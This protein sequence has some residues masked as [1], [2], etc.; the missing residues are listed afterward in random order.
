[1]RLIM[2]KI[3]VQ[4]AYTLLLMGFLMMSAPSWCSED[5]RMSQLAFPL[6]IRLEGVGFFYGVGGQLG[7]VIDR[8][9]DIMALKS[10]GSVDAEGFLFRRIPLYKDIFT[11]DYGFANVNEV[12]FES[13]YIRGF[14]KDHPFKQVMK[15]KG[16]FISLSTKRF[17]DV[18]KVGGGFGDTFVRFRGYKRMDGT[19]I[20]FF[21]A[22]LHDFNTQLHFLNFDL[23]ALNNQGHHLGFKGGLTRVT[24]RLGQSDQLVANFNVLYRWELHSQMKLIFSTKSSHAKVTKRYSSLST[25]KGQCETI[26][27]QDL[28]RECKR[29]EDKVNHFINR[30]NFQG[31][32][33]PLGGSLGMRAYRELRFKSAHTAMSMVAFDWNPVKNFPLE[34]S[35]FFELGH[36]S[37][38]YGKLYKNS[39][40]SAGTGLRYYVAKKLPLRL[41]A[42]T[43][44]EGTSWFFTVG[45][46][47]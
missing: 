22:G 46:P 32:A 23:W 44:Q 43:G 47:Y 30:S 3:K 31:T 26:N 8:K 13:T 41:E 21:R 42:A 36:A 12:E 20:P 16:N 2:M 10:L 18:L 35:F 38:D 40:Y 5:E 11:V 9:V 14:E 39:R 17:W 1:M 24:R 37:E 15:G 33:N 34:V 4:F 7:N 45:L 27:D 25:I 28:Q 6:L 29:L 19:D